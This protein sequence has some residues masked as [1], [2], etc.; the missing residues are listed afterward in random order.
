MNWEKARGNRWSISVNKLSAIALLLLI[1]LGCTSE[2]KK[3]EATDLNN[4]S[5]V[6]AIQDSVNPQKILAYIYKNAKTLGICEGEID[7]NTAQESSKVYPVS[8]GKYL[9]E[10]LCFLGAYQGNYEYFLYDRQASGVILKPL[11]FDIFEIDDSGKITKKQSN[12]IGGLTEFIPEKQELTILTKYR[13]LGDCGALAKYQWQQEEFK[14]L[15]YRIKNECDG[16]YI[17]PEQYSRIYP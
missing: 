13:G 11:E 4:N 2:N 9:V 3:T 12:S 16:I 17:E 5:N 15:E 10:V 8:D 1:N 6:I 14:L 7:V